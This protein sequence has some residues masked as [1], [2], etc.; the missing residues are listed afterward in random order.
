MRKINGF[1]L[2]YCLNRDLNE[3][4]EGDMETTEKKERSRQKQPHIQKVSEGFCSLGK[5]VQ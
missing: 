5:I 4:T 2:K 3:D 1:L